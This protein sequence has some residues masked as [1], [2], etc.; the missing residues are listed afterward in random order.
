[1]LGVAHFSSLFKKLDHLDMGKV[2]KIIS[3]FPS[4]IEDNENRYLYKEAMKYELMDI[5]LSSK[6]DKSLGPDGWIVEFYEDLFEILGETL[7]NVECYV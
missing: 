6:R 2:L 7:L 1:V 3:Y 4:L 5:L